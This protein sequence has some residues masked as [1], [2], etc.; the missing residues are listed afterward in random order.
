MLKS[1]HQRVNQQWNIISPVSSGVSALT[2]ANNCMCSRGS[3]GRG[4][5][6]LFSF[7]SEEEQNGENQ[8]MKVDPQ[9]RVISTR[10]RHAAAQWRTLC[11]FGLNPTQKRKLAAWLR[12]DASHAVAYAEI[13]VV[14][15]QLLRL[16]FTKRRV[17]Q[18]SS[19]LRSHWT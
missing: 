5:T 14:W 1:L 16:K 6:T 17:A 3:N 7:S 18:S 11:D 15:D 2:N 12:T 4:V 8:Q 10:V 13:E 19:E 9:S